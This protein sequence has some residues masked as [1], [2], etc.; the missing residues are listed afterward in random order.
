[1]NENNNI[2]HLSD[3]IKNPNKMDELRPSIYNSFSKVPKAHLIKRGISFFIDIC[4]ISLIKIALHLGYGIFVAEFLAPLKPEM[5][6]ALMNG[7][8][9][10]HGIVFSFIYMGYFLY[11][12]YVLNGKT[13]GKM[14]TG[15]RVINMNYLHQDDSQ[16]QLSFSNSLR[17][18]LGYM[19]CYLSFGI[20]FIFNFVSEDKRGLADYVSNS[21]TVSD[22]WLEHF[23]AVKESTKD[24]VYIDVQNLKSA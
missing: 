3:F 7:N 18:S 9:A 2:V 19:A 15:L 11:S 20:F 4:T 13:L 1:M 23:K 17:R 10:I 16:F 21:L 22:D 14:A 24:H 12:N 6:H 8:I 5:K